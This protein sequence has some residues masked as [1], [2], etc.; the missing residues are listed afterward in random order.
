MKNKSHAEQA[1]YQYGYFHKFSCSTDVNN[2]TDPI[3]IPDI[4]VNL[5]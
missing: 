1:D 4:V 3:I 5:I 2:L